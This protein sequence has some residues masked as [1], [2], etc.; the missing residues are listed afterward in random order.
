[1]TMPV[2]GFVLF[3]L[4]V[5]SLLA[6]MLVKS[7]LRGTASW[8]DAANHLALGIAL[9]AGSILCAYL[10]RVAIWGDETAPSAGVLGMRTLLKWGHWGVWFAAIGI[11]FSLVARG[12][13]RIASLIAS[14]FFA[15][16]WLLL[17]PIV[18]AQ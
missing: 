16:F 6:T 2:F 7:L 1:M 9:I 15:L 10:F 13:A 3:F 11:A 8:R 5:I 18:E 14:V 12:W 17:F 4:I